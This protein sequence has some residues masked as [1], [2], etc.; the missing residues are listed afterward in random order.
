MKKRFF[1]KIILRRIKF[2]NLNKMMRLCRKE[3]ILMLKRGWIMKFFMFTFNLNF[4][5]I[6]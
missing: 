3:M 5:K 2:R 1:G 6:N 4:G